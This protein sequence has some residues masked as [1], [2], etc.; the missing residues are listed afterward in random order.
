MKL[1]ITR[2]VEQRETIEIQFPYYYKHDLMFDDV[3]SVI[4]GKAEEQRNT[5]IHVTYGY[6]NKERRFELEIEEKPAATVAC[7]MTDE[8]SSNEAE[9][10]AAKEK[11]LAA[12]RDA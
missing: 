5:K 2:N 11:L 12:A 10:R 1:E 7:Y 9:Y 8:H 4:Y 6:S 3:D